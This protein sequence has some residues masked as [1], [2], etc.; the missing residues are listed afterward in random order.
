MFMLRDDK[1]NFIA[2]SAP[3]AGHH[4][5]QHNDYLCLLECESDIGV[6]KDDTV[7]IFKTR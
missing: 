4:S 1:L 6:S 2:L 7:V 5:V 3:T